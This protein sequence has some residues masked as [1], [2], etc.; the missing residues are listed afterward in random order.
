MESLIKTEPLDI[1]GKTGENILLLAGPCSAETEEQ[2]LETARELSAMG[3]NIFRA[4][5]WKPRTRPGAFEGVGSAGFPWLRRVR[6]ETGMKFAIEVATAN[7]VYEALKF[8]TDIVWIGARTTANPFAVQEIAEALRGVN[9]PV[10][11]KNPVNPDIDLW[12][13]AF[14][15]INRAGI[16]KLGAIHR[17]FSSIE[18]S[19]FRN[20]PIW[21]IPLQFSQRFP[22]II[23]INDPSHISGHRDLVGYVAM[24]AVDLGFGGLMIESHSHPEKALSDKEQQ[25]KPSE[26]KVLIDTILNRTSATPLAD[27]SEDL[28]DLRNQ[29]DYFDHELLFTLLSRMRVSEKIG[30]YKKDKK[31]TA[32]QTTRWSE[33]LSNRLSEG[34]RMGLRGEFIEG[35]FDYIHQES[36]KIQ[37]EK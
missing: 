4:G 29:I 28:E 7:H 22:E 5:L 30:I 23:M 27:F 21:E 36:I 32:V 3:V 24:K 31:M 12:I 16:N 17:G 1:S 19:G 34:T 35:L 20:Q 33:I 37:I 6:E 18:R 14:E 8:G 13:G 10:F 15:R 26:L 25:L 2:T 11:I 9:I